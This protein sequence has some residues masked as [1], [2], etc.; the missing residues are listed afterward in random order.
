MRNNDYTN[1]LLEEMRDYMKAVL[2]AVGDIQMTVKNQPTRDEFEELRQDVRVINAGLADM[3]EE[4]RR[5]KRDKFA[6]IQ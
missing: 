4:L 5:H 6:H 2:E 3:S 1:V